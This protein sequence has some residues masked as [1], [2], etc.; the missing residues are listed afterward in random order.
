MHEAGTEK[1]SKEIDPP[2]HF[3]SVV[4]CDGPAEGAQDDH[5]EYLLSE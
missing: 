1:G 4:M 2:N 5:I 3:V